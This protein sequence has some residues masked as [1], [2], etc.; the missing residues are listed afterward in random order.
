MTDLISM[1]ESLQMSL[2]AHR[3]GADLESSPTSSSPVT[4]LT[5]FLGAGKSTLLGAAL[6]APPP[7]MIIRAIVNDI[8]ALTFDPSLLVAGGTDATV[9]LANGCA[10][11]AVGGQLGRALGAA[12]AFEPDLIVLEASGIADPFALALVVEASPFVRLDRVVAVVNGQS[13]ERQLADPMLRPVVLR[14]LDACEVVVI[15]RAERLTGDEPHRVTDEVARLAPGRP[16]VL[17]S[18]DEPAVHALLPQAMRGAALPG[19][20]P[21]TSSGIAR[22]FTTVTLAQRRPLHR[23]HIEEVLA[24]RPSTV[25]RCKG[26]LRATEGTVVIQSAGSDTSVSPVDVGCLDASNGVTITGTDLGDITSLALDLGL[27]DPIGGLHEH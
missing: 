27:A 17:S 8:G 24:A 3:P 15:S 1:F 23:R 19:F 21:P 14:Q 22:G 9:E 26:R 6:Q 2:A 4:L 7:G 12:A 10:C 25:L 16:V 11:C 5:G 20:G 18:L 13:L